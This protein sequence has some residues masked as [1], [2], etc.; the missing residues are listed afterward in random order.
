M[1]ALGRSPSI[2]V[3]AEAEAADVGADLA[4]LLADEGDLPAGDRAQHL[5]GADRVEC[6]EAVEDEDRDLHG[7]MVAERR[8]SRQWQERQ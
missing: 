6:G 7:R 1:S 2:V 3:D 5:V 4:A 8:R